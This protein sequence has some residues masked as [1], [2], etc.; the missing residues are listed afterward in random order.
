M[1]RHI[2]AKNLLAGYVLCF[3]HW[4]ITLCKRFK[5]LSSKNFVFFVNEWSLYFKILFNII[6]WSFVISVK[7]CFAIIRIEYVCIFIYKHFIANWA[8]M[9]L[10]RFLP[11]NAAPAAY[12]DF[13]MHLLFKFNWVV[14]TLQ[15]ISFHVK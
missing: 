4:V 6:N 7:I 8:G 3:T 12:I 2:I 14:G 15:N 13:Y 1:T 9:A 5:V 11:Q 10:A